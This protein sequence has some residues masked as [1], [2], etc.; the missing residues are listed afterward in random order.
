MIGDLAQKAEWNDLADYLKDTR[1]SFGTCLAVAAALASDNGNGLTIGLVQRRFHPRRF[2]GRA[3][4]RI[5]R[6]DWC[7][8]CDEGECFH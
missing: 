4:W 1:A 5:R 7:G 6:Y 2:L 3:G 8:I